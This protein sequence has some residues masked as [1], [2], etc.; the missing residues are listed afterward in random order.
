MEIATKNRLGKMPFES[1]LVRQFAEQVDQEGFVHL[2]ITAVHAQLAGGFPQP[3]R[4]PWDRLLAA[5]GQLERLT[6]IT[7]DEKL[8]GFGVKTLW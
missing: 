8:N 3:H 4:D 1:E 2:P 7:C 6:L 5:Q